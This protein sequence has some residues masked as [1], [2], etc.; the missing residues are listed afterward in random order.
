MATAKIVL[1]V[2]NGEIPCDR[3]MEAGTGTEGA[4][5]GKQVAEERT[6]LPVRQLFVLCLMRFAEPI[7]FFVLSLKVLYVIILGLNL[8]HKS[9]YFPL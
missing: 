7:S 6:P 2:T 8:I 1:S 3:A 5:S 9:G 4:T